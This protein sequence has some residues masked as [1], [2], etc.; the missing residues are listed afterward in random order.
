MQSRKYEREDEE[1]Q[2]KG[3]LARKEFENLMTLTVS[4]Y[5]TKRV[6]NACK[7]R[8]RLNQKRNCTYANL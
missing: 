5:E 2:E 1:W 4:Q 7:N 6:S 8:M 3:V